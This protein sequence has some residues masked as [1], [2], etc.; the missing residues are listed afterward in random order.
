MK[1]H[2]H[3][4][5]RSALEPVLAGTG[6]SAPAAITIDATRDAKHGDFATNVA[7][8]LAKALGK[9]PRA[10]AEAI[11]KSLPP[12]ARVA[13]TEIAG[14]GFIN[15]FLAP[16]AFQAVVPEILAAKE[17]FG[18]APKTQGKVLVEVAAPGSGD[19]PAWAA[20]LVVVAVALASLWLLLRR[21]RAYEVVT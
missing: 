15:F 17:Q 21:I 14:P 10:V 2:L 1:D 7:L 8:A 16:G 3:A 9:P 5:L 12:S 11:V 4:L 6:V 18:R 13:R 19:L 20:W